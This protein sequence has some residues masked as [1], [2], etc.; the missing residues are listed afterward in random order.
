MGKSRA[1]KK[2]KNLVPAPGFS[3]SA[4]AAILFLK[5]FRNWFHFHPR[6]PMQLAQLELDVP[7]LDTQ[8]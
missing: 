6:R 5:V 1:Q 2:E 8:H 7:P 3:N 4:K